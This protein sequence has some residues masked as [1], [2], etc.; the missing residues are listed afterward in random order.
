MGSRA[1]LRLTLNNSNIMI[2]LGEKGRTFPGVVG[3]TYLTPMIRGLWMN[4]LH[5]SLQRLYSV[6]DRRYFITL[7]LQGKRSR[8]THKTNINK[9]LFLDRAEF[10][11]I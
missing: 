3:K 2:K 4:L 1:K 9:P 5:V 7:C 6:H 11:T 8:L 10:G